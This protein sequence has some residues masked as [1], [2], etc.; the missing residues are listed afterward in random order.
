EL[1]D[2]IWKPLGPVITQLE[3]PPRDVAFYMSHTNELFGENAAGWQRFAAYAAWHE[4]F[5]RVGLPVDIIFESQVTDGELSDYDAL[6]IPF[7][8]VTS[9]SAHEQIVK[10]AENGGKVVADHNLGYEVPGV[11][12]LRTDLDH[13]MYPNWAWRR[14]KNEG[15]GVTA[16]Q[17][18]KAMMDVVDEISEVFAPEL[19]DQP[20]PNSFW[21][22]V[23]Q[24]EFE[25]VPYI[26]AINDKREPGDQVGEY[27]TMFERGVPLY[28]GEITTAGTENIAAVYDLVRHQ[29]VP[30]ETTS[31]GVRWNHTYEP[32]FG[33]IFACLPEEIADIELTVPDDPVLRGEAFDLQVRI[34]DTD[35]NP[36]R[37]AIPIEVT[38]ED[39]Q[40]AKCEYSDYY[41]ATGGV[42]EMTGHIAI[43]DTRGPWKVTARDLASGREITEYLR[44]GQEPQF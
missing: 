5:M 29:R 21:L 18:T 11:Q 1:A 17:R 32:A 14:V 33:T 20:V 39:G 2:R 41:A 34:L 28:N 4:A 16:Q 40:G 10:F 43:N 42:W 25:G 12:T 19:S 15:E 23:N 13:M 3:T 7:G 27:E 35:G 38:I 22:I 24:R 9:Q 26:F 37:G 30:V 31:R 36:V 6:F 44:V 8:E